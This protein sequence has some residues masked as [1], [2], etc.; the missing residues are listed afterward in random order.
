MVVVCFAM[1]LVCPVELQ[2]LGG[3][4]AQ[5]TLQFLYKA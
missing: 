3:W 2:V 4:R 5:L 1:S